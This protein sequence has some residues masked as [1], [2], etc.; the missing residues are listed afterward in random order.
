M[1]MVKQSQ[2]SKKCLKLTDW[3]DHVIDEPVR[4]VVVELLENNEKDVEEMTA[5]ITITL[6]EEK[7]Q[8]IAEG[9]KQAKLELARK[10]RAKGMSI[11]EIVELT[12]LELEVIKNL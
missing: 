3:L 7:A 9:E 2:D 5:N 6:M 8:A 4:K 10:L 1:T 11:E 12:D